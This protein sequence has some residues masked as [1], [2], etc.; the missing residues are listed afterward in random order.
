M[1]P[2]KFKFLLLLAVM[3]FAFTP[4]VDASIIQ[5]ATHFIQ[6]L[7]PGDM[8]LSVATLAVVPLALY[9]KQNTTITTE[10]IQ[11]L[12]AKYG[13]IKI[14]TVV[15]EAPIYNELGELV[16]KGEFYEFAVR[17][18]DI[19]MVRMLMNYAKQGKTDEYLG[20][21]IKNL[22]VG[23]DVDKLK[24]GDSG[25]DGIVYLGFA[26]KVDE[27]LKPYESFLANA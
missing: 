23:G 8:G 20:A 2:I 13:K 5:P 15:V 22:V 7:S 19:S 17:R 9:V 11:E 27:F 10:L 21:F 26:T 1:K 12:T 3:A 24:S 14:I 4:F 18:P 6:S 25:G 16:T